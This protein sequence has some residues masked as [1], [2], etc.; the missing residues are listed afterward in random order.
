MNDFNGV[1][2]NEYNAVN[3]PRQS[4]MKYS[5]NQMSSLTRAMMVTGFGFLGTFVVG[6]LS[7]LLI[8]NM[9]KSGNPW[10][11][12]RNLDTMFIISGISLFVSVILTLI[13]SFRVYKASTAFA[14]ITIVLYCISN[15][16][17]FGFL[18]WAVELPEILIAFGMLGLIFL[19]T[20]GIAKIMSFKAAMSLTRILMI[21]MVIY[22]IA[23]LTFMFLSLFGVLTSTTFEYI[24][25]VV[26]A[27]SGLLSVLYMVY[28]LWVIQNLDKFNMDE[29]LT[30][31]LSIFMG[32]Q[33]LINLINLLWMI[34]RIFASSR[35]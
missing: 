10:V 34:L 32:F 11:Q 12:A 15:G 21:A 20:F 27:V 28:E 30:K 16:I 25:L 6:L 24:Y 31:R 7:W 22:M 5:T 29:Q 8:E 4:K 26:V 2:R 23:T 3:A 13:W 35:N 18:F 9:L 33:V 14:T 1:F 17:G 19:G